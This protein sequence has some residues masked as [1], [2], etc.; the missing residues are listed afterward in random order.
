MKNQEEM[1]EQIRT[2]VLQNGADVCGFAT[3]DRFADAPEGFSPL[4]VWKDCK[5]VIS[6]GIALPKGLTY[7]DSNLIYGYFN[8]D[9]AKQLDKISFQSAKLIEREFKAIAMPLP[10]DGPYDYWQEETMTGKGI[11]S[12]RH[13]ATACGLG[14]IGKNSLLLNPKYGTMLIVGAILTNLELASDEYSKDI[15]IP[16]CSKCINSCPA[17]AIENRTVNQKACRTNTF[18]KSKRG[19]DTVECKACRTVCPRKFGV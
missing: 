4:D 17:H 13:V 19:F 11:I 12:M 18:G 6:L 9:A 1:K 15:C 10:C 7:T 3:M 16:G 8:A 5:S 14:T 2:I